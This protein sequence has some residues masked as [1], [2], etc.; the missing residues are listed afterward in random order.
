MCFKRRDGAAYRS[1]WQP[2]LI[3]VSFIAGILAFPVSAHDSSKGYH[4]EFKG[5]DHWKKVFDD[6]ARDK[7]QKPKEVIDKL[8]VKPGD[9][10]ADIGAG[11]GYFSLR[12]A[13]A[14][15]KAKVLAADVE[16]EMI[17]HLEKQSKERKL[18]NV[19]PFQ[20]EAAKPNLPE[21]VDLALI[22]DTLHHIDNRIEYLKQLKQVLTKDGRVAV[23]DFT[24]E[25]PTGP[26]KKHRIRKE[27][28]VQEFE[29][30]GYKLV[31]DLDTL[32]NQYF[33]IFRPGFSK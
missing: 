15:P 10:V 20:I 33:L 23:I 12:I 25:S 5:V 26:P 28:A 13:E 8:K 4:K 2:L 11:T 29:S 19:V 1:I 3:M 32:P 14:H 17:D 21:P 9:V 18:S 27:D 30:A 24:Q 22:V 7:W 31:D 16:A 6:P